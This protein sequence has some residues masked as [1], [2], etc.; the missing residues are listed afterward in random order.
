MDQRD[1]VV[2]VAVEPQPHLAVR[3]AALVDDADVTYSDSKYRQNA[4]NGE[5]VALAPRLTISA[6]LATLLPFGLR[7]SLDSPG[8][9]HAGQ[10]RLGHQPRGSS[11]ISP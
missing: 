8:R 6:G 9:A 11:T 3:V 5:S 2:A 4:G 7:G 1:Q 10:A